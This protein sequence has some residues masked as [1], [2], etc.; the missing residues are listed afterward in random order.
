MSNSRFRFFGLALLSFFYLGGQ[1]A[2]AIGNGEQKASENLDPSFVQAESSQDASK[3]ERENRIKILQRNQFKTYPLPKE[4]VN[5][6]VREFF[7]DNDIIYIPGK[8][9]LVISKDFGKTFEIKGIENGLN[10]QGESRFGSFIKKLTAKDLKILLYAESPD[11]KI[12]LSED[13]GDHFVSFGIEE[14]LGTTEVVGVHI[15][16]QKKMNS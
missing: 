8:R 7:V 15:D 10:L 1:N 4:H 14:F 5:H 11:K 13:G 6:Y 3:L 2:S 16:D 12:F 9:G